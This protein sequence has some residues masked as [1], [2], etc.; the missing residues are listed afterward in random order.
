MA[1][2]RFY[3]SA[4]NAGKSTILLQ[5]SYNYRERGMDTLLLA[6]SVDTRY[7]R[8]RITSRLGIAAEAIVIDH[9][10]NI[11]DYVWRVKQK[12]EKLACVLIDEAHFLSK[13]QVRQLTKVVDEVHLPV[14]A[15]GIRV[16]FRGEP[17]E[18]SQYLLA[19]ADALIE[20]KTICHCGRKATMNMRVDE[21]GRQVT[22]GQQIEIGGNDRYVATCRW[23]FYQGDSG[24]RHRQV[25][26]ALPKTIENEQSKDTQSYE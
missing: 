5:S 18:G 10:F 23:H 24:P 9:D 6:P 14:L 22:E 3:Y 17:F 4:M 12:N 15:Y 1:K 25:N 16:D 13:A 8:G 19:L 20:V 2:L 21:Y 7:G 11:F 26:T